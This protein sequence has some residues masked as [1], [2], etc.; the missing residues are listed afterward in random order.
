MEKVEVIYKIKTATEGQILAHLK[1]CN[2]NFRPPL[3]ERVDVVEYSRKLYGKSITFEAWRGNDLVG[4]LAVYLNKGTR[5]SAYI[6]N[7]SVS[8]SSMGM[9]IAS[10]LL[11]NCVGYAIEQD[12]KEIALEVHKANRQ[13]LGLYR[14]FDFMI[15]D[16]SERG[17]LRMRKGLG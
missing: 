11:H 13:A 1:E 2:E 14:K 4:L 8:K 6:T 12:C 7:V 10:T 15:T 17:F 3:D 16:E 5:N 9:G